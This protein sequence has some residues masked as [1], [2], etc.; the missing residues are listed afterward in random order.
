MQ[1]T[2]EQLTDPETKTAWA[3]AVNTDLIEGRGRNYFKHICDIEATAIR[4]A[5]KADV[6]GANGSVH[7]IEL[8]KIGFIWYGP[9][10]IEQANNSDIQLQRRVDLKNDAIEK[11]RAAGLTDDD[12]KNLS[13]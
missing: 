10:V 7:Q 8:I 12:L 9:I 2:P 11:A 5:R 6:Q 1:I 4:L 13:L 3:V